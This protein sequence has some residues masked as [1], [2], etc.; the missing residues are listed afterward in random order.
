MDEAEVRTGREGMRVLSR[1]G[2][3][4]RHP[5][6]AEPVR[7]GPFRK[8]KASGDQVR[9]PDI[10]EHLDTLAKTENL[11][12]PMIPADPRNDELWNAGNRKDCVA[13]VLS[14]RANHAKGF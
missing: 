14:N 2:T 13:A 7:A 6:M 8:R 3:F 1:H 5:R 11:D 4:R 12:I 10:L 9:L